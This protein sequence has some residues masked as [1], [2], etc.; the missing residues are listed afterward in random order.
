MKNKRAIGQIGENIAI[1]YLKA[2]GYKVL[3][4]NY[5]KNHGEI[6]II[7]EFNN[8]IVFVEVKYRKN[9]SFGHPLESISE[10]KIRKILETANL[11]LIDNDINKNIRFDV[12]S[13]LENNGINETE[14]IINAF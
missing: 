7:T 10:K 5:V 4:T 11:Y 6:D 1:E 9:L 13:I 8:T 12:V 2:K 3:K 14:H